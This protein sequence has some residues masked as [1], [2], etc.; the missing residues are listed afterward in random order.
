MYEEG[1]A[2]A[3]QMELSRARNAEP[4]FDEIITEAENI[5]RTVINLFIN[6][7]WYFIIDIDGDDI[8]IS[9]SF[10]GGKYSRGSRLFAAFDNG[11]FEFGWGYHS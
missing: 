2:A 4:N 11:H 1:R 5:R 7:L 3:K 9:I 8:W 10:A 6:L